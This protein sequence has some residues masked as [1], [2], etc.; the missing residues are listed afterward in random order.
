MMRY[1][2]FLI[3]AG[4][5]VAAANDDEAC[6]PARTVLE[7]DAD[8]NGTLCEDATCCPVGFEAV[9]INDGAIVCL[10]LR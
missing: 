9:G 1:L 2:W 7:L 8:V 3:L 5:P 10:E 4:C 6:L